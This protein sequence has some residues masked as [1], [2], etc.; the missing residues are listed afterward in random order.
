MTS[1]Q[2]ARALR[3]R[4]VAIVILCLLVSSILAIAQDAADNLVSAGTDLFNKHKFNEA[5]ANFEKA[6]KLRAEQCSPCLTNM[7]MC[8]MRM[9][10]EGSAV[11]LTVKAYSVAA[12][13]HDRADALS[14]RGQIQLSFG[15]RSNDKKKLADSA[16]S[17]RAAFKEDPTAWVFVLKTAEA[18]F[19]LEKDD[20]GK[21]EL[22]ALLDHERTGPNADLARLYLSDPRRARLEFAPAI[23]ITTLTGERIELAKLTGKV[24]VLD[25]WA[26]SCPACR[27]SLSDLKDLLKKYPAEKLVLISVSADKEDQAWRDFVAKNQM[28][29]YQCRDASVIDAFDV[30]AFPTY[31]I[32]DREGI[33]RERVVGMDDQ[34]S[35]AYKLKEPLKKLL[36]QR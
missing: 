17:F 30:R 2:S 5:Y 34:Q 28:S 6:N 33:V 31:L 24:V 10:D 12:T 23:T 29:W 35:V 9:G 7:A 20:E 19:R 18:L 8:K 25:F 26:T 1:P 32:L 4:G 11:K 36:E 21:R 3:M 27:A 16:E 15:I 13:P 22:Q 14:V